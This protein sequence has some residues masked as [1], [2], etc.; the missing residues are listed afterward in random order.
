MDAT[1]IEAKGLRL[2]VWAA[3]FMAALGIGFY[4]PTRSQAILLDGVFSGIGFFVSLL[5]L[6]VAR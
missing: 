1:A 4:F 5:T 3:L 2:T 6:K